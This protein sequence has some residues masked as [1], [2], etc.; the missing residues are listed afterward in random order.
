M[1][2]P[3]NLG[4]SGPSMSPMAMP[5][6]SEPEMYFPS[7]HLEGE[8]LE[9]PDEGTITFRYR[10]NRESEDKRTETCCYDID[11]LEIVSV[12]GA[13]AAEPKPEDALDKIKAELEGDSD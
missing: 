12:K 3:V 4:K 9:L 2:Y 8:G 5:E 11:L 10:T 1:E 6:R 13:K 7:T